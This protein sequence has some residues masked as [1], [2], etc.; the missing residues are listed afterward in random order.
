MIDIITK[1]GRTAKKWEEARKNLS[2]RT[3]RT[4]KKT[5]SKPKEK[6]WIR[7][8]FKPRKEFKERKFVDRQIGG[9]VKTFET[10]TEGIAQGELDRR[11][12]ARECMRCAWPADR[13]RQP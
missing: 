11:K 6:F 12:K 4:E 9:S 10:Q 3:L 7:K 13:K 1:A 2:T 8:D 5:D